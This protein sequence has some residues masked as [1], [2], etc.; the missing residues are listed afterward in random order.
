[1]PKIL[2]K[3]FLRQKLTTVTIFRDKN[4]IH[5]SLFLSKT[6]PQKQIFLFS[7]LL[8]LHFLFEEKKINFSY[9][10][11][12]YFR[13]GFIFKLFCKKIKVI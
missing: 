7:S 13:K 3:T 8:R 9:T 6:K 10:S 1:M 11:N 2:I 4:A 5:Q 12:I